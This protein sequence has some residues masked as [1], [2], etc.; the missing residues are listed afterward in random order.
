MQESAVPCPGSPAKYLPEMEME[1]PPTKRGAGSCD[2]ATS[3]D[4]GAGEAAS[5]SSGTLRLPAR[6]SGGDV[7]REFCQGCRR[8]GFEVVAGSAQC[9]QIQRERGCHACDRRGCWQES[10]QCTF[11]G[12]EREGH[13]DAAATGSSAPHMFSRLPVAITENARRKLVRV[14]EQ[15]FVKGAASGENNNCLIHTLIGVLQDHVSFIADPRWI[16]SELRRRFPSGPNAVTAKNYLD[17]RAHWQDILSLISESACAQGFL[18]GRL[19][20]PE[21]FRITCVEEGRQV[22]GDVVGDGPTDL[23]ILNEYLQHFVPLLRRRDV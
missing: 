9:V 23:F 5:S 4:T 10:P 20:R 18:D 17:L 3:G 14:G 15:V 13:R 7:D 8:L 16:R 1:R 22:V 2:D 21:A 19:I 6:P 11:F 12:R